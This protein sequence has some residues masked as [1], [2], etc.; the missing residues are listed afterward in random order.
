MDKMKIGDIVR[1]L[2]DDYGKIMQETPCF[3]INGHKGKMYE[4][5]LLSKE[6]ATEWLYDNEIIK[7]GRI[8]SIW[9]KVRASI[10]NYL[11]KM[12]REEKPADEE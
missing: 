3:C 10:F 1:T 4:V 12:R 7:C 8:E 11:R 6:E 5:Q 2:Y 9:Q